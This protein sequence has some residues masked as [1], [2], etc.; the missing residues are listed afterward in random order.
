MVVP[1]PVLVK[2]Q[3]PSC[4]DHGLKMGVGD[5]FVFWWNVATR[6]ATRLWEGLRSRWR[7]WK[8]GQDPS[9]QMRINAGIS[10]IQGREDDG[11][12]GLSSL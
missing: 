5:V 12:Y 11:D 2:I 7:G 10:E 6:R 4:L 9:L 3:A 8:L 1:V